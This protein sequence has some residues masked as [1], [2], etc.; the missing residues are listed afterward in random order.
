M[1]E[2]VDIV[3]TSI[4]YQCVDIRLNPVKADGKGNSIC[5]LL[6]R[7]CLRIMEE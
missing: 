6:H 7:G 1:K 3:V 5:L 2:R 4:E